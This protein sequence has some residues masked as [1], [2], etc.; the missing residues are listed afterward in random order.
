MIGSHV[1]KGWSATQRVIA[2]S[3]GEAEYYGLVKGASMVLGVKSMHKEMGLPVR[4]RVNTDAS[5]AKAGASGKRGSLGK[6]VDAKRRKRREVEYEEERE[7]APRQTIDD[8]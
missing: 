3:S 6:P 4:V 7:I 2:L 1:L 5:A 8:W